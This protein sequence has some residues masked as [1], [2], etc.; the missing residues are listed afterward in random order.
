[1]MT[2]LHGDN[3]EASRTEFQRLITEARSKDI[4]RLEGRSLDATELVQAYGSNSLFGNKTLLAIENLFST[5]LKKAKRIELFIE[6][7][8]EIHHEADLIVW[9]EKELPKTL[10]TKINE[11]ISVRLFKIPVLIFQF[12]DSIG[13]NRGKF[14]LTTYQ[15]LEEIQ[16]AEIIF[17]MISRRLRQLLMVSCGVAPEGLQ[18]WQSN[19]LRAQIRLF[20]TERLRELYAQ[21]L[22]I[23][24]SIKSGTSPFSLDSHIRQFLL[25]L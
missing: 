7:L 17:L 16:A 25:S 13:P 2:L 11:R 3:V 22:R 12:L 6:L 9:E 18:L 19:K 8:K 14:L 10:L 24:F 21:L 15:K 23:D 4:R 1:M 20:T 5:Q